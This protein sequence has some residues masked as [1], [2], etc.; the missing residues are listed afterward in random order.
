MGLTEYYGRFVKDYGRIARPLTSLLKK[1]EFMWN[2]ETT[3]AFEALKQAVT[4]LLVLIFPDI[5]KEFTVETDASG[6]CIGAV[7]SQN[8]RLIAF[9]SQG[10]SCQG[11]IKSVY[12]RELLAIVK[13]ITKWQAITKWLHFLA[14]KEFV[15]KTEQRSLKYLL[16][17]KA[18]STIQQRWVSK[19]IGLKYKIEY[20]PGVDN[21]VANALSKRPHQEA[22]YQYTMVTPPTL[23][24]IL[25]K[26]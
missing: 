8:K 19:S 25:L 5:Q 18:V 23:D 12:E 15:I 4:N 24:T 1:N 20:T 6:T 16:D 3:S 14:G 7:L 21:K 26:K 2:D 11:R 13:A 17:Q 22:A 10:Y 9:L